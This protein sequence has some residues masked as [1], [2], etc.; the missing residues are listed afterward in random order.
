MNGAG[1]AENAGGPE[2]VKPRRAME[3]FFDFVD[4]QSAAVAMSRKRI[5]LAGAAVIA[6][7]IAEFAPLDLPRGHHMSPCNPRCSSPPD[8][9]D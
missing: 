5:E 2:S 6:I 4:G 1:P 3:T 9:D 8:G 7:A